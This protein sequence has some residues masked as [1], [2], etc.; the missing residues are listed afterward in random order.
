VDDVV[1]G[2][3]HAFR[4]TILRGGVR[5]EHPELHVV[6]KEELSWGGVVELAPIV[7]LDT[8]NLAAELSTHKREEL[9]DS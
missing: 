7:T 2:A 1:G 4:F 9:G 6:G 3:H 5:A 8:P